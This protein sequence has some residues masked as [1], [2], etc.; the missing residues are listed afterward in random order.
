MSPPS[1]PGEE[2]PCPF[3]DSSGSIRVAHRP[4]SHSVTRCRRPLFH[5]AF[6]PAFTAHDT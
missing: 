6:K 5:L 3:P 1:S 2:S 4:V